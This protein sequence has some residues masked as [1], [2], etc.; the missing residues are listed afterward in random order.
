MERIGE[1]GGWQMNFESLSETWF[2]GAMSARAASRIE[3]RSATGPVLAPGITL[4]DEGTVIHGDG[5]I[6]FRRRGDFGERENFRPGSWSSACDTAQV[7]K[8]WDKLGEI[9]PES[10]PA[11]VADPGDTMRYLT[12][13]VA[14]RVHALAIAPTDPSQPA[15]GDVFMQ[16]IY[17]IL[18]LR[19]SG[20]C[21]WAVESALAG[22]VRTAK[23]AEAEIRF[24]NPGKGPIALVFEGNA[25][26][27]DFHFRFAQDREEIPYPEWHHC[28]SLPA[29]ADK[30]QLISLEPG[31]E[32][33]R[34]VFFPCRFPDSGKYI[35][36]ISYRQARYLDTLA[37]IPVLTGVAYT[38]MAEF[39]I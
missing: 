32:L 8:L 27:S 39:S 12:A 22:L 10:F 16:E 38:E 3:Y 6:E 28:D 19:E 20:E 17:P 9:G 11:R 23:G 13:Y 18:R 29:E 2:S 25:G 14:G 4:C 35:G 37:G 1:G 33:A 15:P 24:R 31:T 36:K 34:K 26:S 7:E 30:V 5:K 21:H